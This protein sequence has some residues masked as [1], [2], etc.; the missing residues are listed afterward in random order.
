MNDQGL[1]KMEGGTFAKP[2]FQVSDLVS[3][4]RLI[5]ETMRA[6]MKDN[7]HYG[8]I[9]GTGNK[10]SLLKPGA[11]KLCLLFRYATDYEIL[12]QS[13][14]DDNF[15]RYVVRC[16]LT[17]ILTDR[18]AGNGIG[19]C[20]SRETKYRFRS[21]NTGKAV[22]EEYWASRDPDILGGP[23]FKPRKVSGAWTIFEQ[24]EHDNPWDY[25]NTLLKMAEKRAL[26]AAILNAT[27]ASD[28]FTQDLEDL[29]GN[30]I[31]EDT[32]NEDRSAP[33]AGSAPS[34]ASKGTGGG[35]SG[36]H[37]GL[38]KISEAQTKRLYAIWKKEAPRLSD[39]EVGQYIE[40]LTGDPSPR[41]LERGDQYSG[42]VEWLKSYDK[43]VAEI[44]S[45]TAQ[46]DIP[47]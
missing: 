22:P 28:I 17:H 9:P 27:A 26:V 14:A 24:V 1:A 41:S 5:Q 11:E 40:A 18:T 39:A 37:G 34:G 4:V 44:G 43:P 16:S 36:P 45:S 46:D 13:Q 38:P 21:T 20:N 32:E 10:P 3:Q 30:G 47:F 25:E 8:V 7:E 33:T 29:R 31:L 6:V 19:A 2:D 42:V 35:G 12:P 23:Q 15:I